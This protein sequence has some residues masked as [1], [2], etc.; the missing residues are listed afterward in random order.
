MYEL[1]HILQGGN[2][3]R[4]VMPALIFDI[5]FFQSAIADDNT[6]RDA[7]Q[8]QVGKHHTRT[9]VAVVQQHFNTGR[10]QFGIELFTPPP[11]P[12]HFS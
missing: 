1:R 3:R 10:S 11:A 4:S 2:L 8:F 12:L 5:A 7:D 9:L 6:M